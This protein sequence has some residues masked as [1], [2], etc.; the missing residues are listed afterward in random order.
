MVSRFDYRTS[1][2]LGV[3]ETP[4]L[5]GTNKIL[6]TVTC[7]RRLN[8]TTQETELK[9]PA[10]VGGSPVEAQVGRGSPQGQSAGSS[11]PGRFPLT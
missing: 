1:T 8:Q 11:S 4:V 7:R 9:L 3:T 10:G 2:G 6:Y 5:E